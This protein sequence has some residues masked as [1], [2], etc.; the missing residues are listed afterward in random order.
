MLERVGDMATCRARYLLRSASVCFGLTPAASPRPATHPGPRS[1]SRL[2]PIPHE[3]FGVLQIERTYPWCDM[4]VAR[5]DSIAEFY[6]GRAGGGLDDPVGAS[7]LELLDDVAGQR[8]LD[9]ACGHGRAALELSRRGAVVTGLDL[10]ARL[11]ERGRI[12]AGEA[13]VE[14]R[15]V[16]GDATLPDVLAGETFEAVASHFALTDIDDLDDVLTTVARVLR[17][18]GPFVFSILHP[19]FAGHGAD[20]PST[21]RPGTSYFDEAG[22]SPPARASVGRSAPATGCSRPTSTPSSITASGQT[23]CRAARVSDWPSEPDLV[24][25]GRRSS[26]GALCTSSDDPLPRPVPLGGETEP[27]GQIWCL[28]GGQKKVNQI[29][30]AIELDLGPRGAAT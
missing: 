30:A 21:W 19:C 8:V 25:S 6:V 1:G 2:V 7:L 15:W 11:L 16:H 22:G 24:G 13:R 27:S 29:A 23:G 14:V 28:R 9:L 26:S 12:A 17:P 10:S 18:G 3:P 5:Y 20:A 4:P